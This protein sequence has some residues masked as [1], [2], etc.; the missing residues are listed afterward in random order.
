MSEMQNLNP[1]GEGSRLIQDKN[2]EEKT[3]IGRAHV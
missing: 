2:L 1:N 3:E